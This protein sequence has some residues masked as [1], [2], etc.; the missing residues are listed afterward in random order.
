MLALIIGVMLV[1]IDAVLRLIIHAYQLHSKL[2]DKVSR[3]LRL[4]AYVTYAVYLGNFWIPILAYLI[5]IGLSTL[6]VA[7]FPFESKGAD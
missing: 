1:M 7:I 2:A 3:I 6:V 5:A 4:V